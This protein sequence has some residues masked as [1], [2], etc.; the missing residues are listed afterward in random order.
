MSPHRI[1]I[2]HF[3]VVV[4]TT[5]FGCER[6]VAP[7]L[8]ADE[9]TALGLRELL[10]SGAGPAEEGGGATLSEPTVLSTKM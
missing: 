2:L 8:N 3:A 1:A 9:S 4:A 6:Q 5:M 7:N 10:E